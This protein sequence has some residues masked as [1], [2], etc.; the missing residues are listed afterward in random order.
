MLIRHVMGNVDHWTCAQQILEQQ[1]ST[2]ICHPIETKQGWSDSIIKYKWIYFSSRM[3][4]WSRWSI[5]SSEKSWS[6]FGRYEELL[7]KKEIFLSLLLP[8]NRSW[9]GF[10]IIQSS[11]ISEDKFVNFSFSYLFTLHADKCPPPRKFVNF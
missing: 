3:R 10:L 1:N 11:R 5:F 6:F 9:S 4:L 2:P 7:W 8:F